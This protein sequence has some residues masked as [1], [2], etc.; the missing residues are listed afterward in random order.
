M[1][2]YPNS[3][4]WKYFIYCLNNPNCLTRHTQSNNL[5]LKKVFLPMIFRIQN[6]YGALTRFER[7]FVFLPDKNLVCA[8]IVI[9]FDYLDLMKE[10]LTH[11]FPD[12]PLWKFF[13]S[14][15]YHDRLGFP[16]F[17]LRLIFI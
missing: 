16:F 9:Y 6:A 12:S 14:F 17:R 5:I 4:Y 13:Y 8:A 7:S 3:I 15:R 1:P 11:V 2:V 10:D